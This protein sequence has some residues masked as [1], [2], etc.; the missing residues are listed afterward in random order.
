MTDEID[1][2]ISRGTGWLAEELQIE[3]G[4][5]LDHHEICRKLRDALHPAPPQAVQEYI[6]G[7]ID[8]THSKLRGTP[9]PSPAKRNRNLLRAYLFQKRHKQHFDRLEKD[10]VNRPYEEA[11]LAIAEELSDLTKDD[12]SEE[13]VRFWMQYGRRGV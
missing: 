2:P 9:P 6:A 8:G 3:R 13:T 5:V 10:G 4:E 11:L 7:L 12:I 1:I